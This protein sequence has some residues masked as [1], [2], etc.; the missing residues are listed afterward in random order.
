MAPKKRPKKAGRRPTAG[1]RVK[2]TARRM[3]TS[4]GLGRRLKEIEDRLDILL[5]EVT[6]RIAA[7]E[8]LLR[9]LNLCTHDDLRHARVFVKDNES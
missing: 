9:K 7:L 8:H 4:P 5:P 1:R 3:I 2:K 6:A